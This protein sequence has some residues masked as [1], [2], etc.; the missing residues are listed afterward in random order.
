MRSACFETRTA[1]APHASR[2]ALRALLSMTGFGTVTL[3]SVRNERVSKG[4]RSSCFETRTA[5]APQHDR[6]CNCHPEERSER[7]RLEGRASCF[8]TRTACAPHASR[9]ALRALLSMTGFATV[10]LRSVRNERVSKGAPSCFETRTAC[11]P[12]H[13]NGAGLGDF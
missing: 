12:Q 5:C 4:V 10:T 8:E 6:V 11:A 13:D 3:R 1:C 7:T 2:R 9:R